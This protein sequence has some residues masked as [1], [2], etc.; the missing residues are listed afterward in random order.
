MGDAT[1]DDKI[2]VVSGAA[3]ATARDR[4]SELVEAFLS[5]R[6]KTTLDAYRRDLEVFAEFMGVASPT[7]AAAVLFQQVPGDANAL[8]LRWRTQLVGEGL[9]AATVNR[10]LAAVRSL[11]KLARMLGLVPWT[12]E[13]PDLDSQAFRDTR[14]PGADGFRRMLEVVEGKTDRGTLRNRAIL[15]MLYG[16]GLRRFEVTGLCIG[17]LDLRGRRAWIL[18]KGRTERELVTIP[19][20]TFTAICDWLRV[21]PGVTSAK[22]GQDVARMPLFVSLDNASFEHRLSNRSIDRI[23]RAIGASVGLHVWPHGLRHAAITEVLDATGGD[24]RTARKFARH[25]NPATTL[26]YD[27]NRE[28]LAGQAAELISRRGGKV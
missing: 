22:A 16:M 18:G 13:V 6:K 19:E 23:V 9:S 14:G 26:L 7:E 15:W 20:A 24:V 27:D 10:R 28:D 17:H 3:L 1:A 11:S 4:V 21:H 5:G 8:V 12:V 25:R 2:V